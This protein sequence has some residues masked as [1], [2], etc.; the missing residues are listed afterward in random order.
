MSSSAAHSTTDTDTKKI[1]F[2]GCK[3]KF[4]LK[5][6]SSS[7]QSEGKQQSMQQ[8]A[9]FFPC[10]LINVEQTEVFVCYDSSVLTAPT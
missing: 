10:W 7:P 4:G 5:F 3:Y 6:N 8:V 9:V 2:Q 1:V